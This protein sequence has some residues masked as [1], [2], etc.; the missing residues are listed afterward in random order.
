MNILSSERDAVV[1]KAACQMLSLPPDTRAFFELEG[2]QLLI[3]VREVYDAG[4][5]AGDTGRKKIEGSHPLVNVAKR[6]VVL[7]VWLTIWPVLITGL[8]IQ[9]IRMC[10]VEGQLHPAVYTCGGLITFVFSLIMFICY[11]GDWFLKGSE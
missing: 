11:C 1:Y 7:V 10:G 8:F 3:N 4:F 6:V 5:R 9:I 2:K